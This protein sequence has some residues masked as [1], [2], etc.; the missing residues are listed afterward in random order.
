MKH[1]EKHNA[2]YAFVKGLRIGGVAAALALLL[3]AAA[4]PARGEEDV[5]WHIDPGVETCSM[6]IDPA[7]TQDQWHS[8]VKQVGAIASFK[9]LAPAETLGRMNFRISV[10]QGNTPVDQRDPAWIN[11]FV[12][13][14]KE[15]PLGDAISYPIIRAALG[16][17]DHVDVGAYWTTAPGANYGMVGGEVKYAFLQE[18]GTRPAAA[19]R[20]SATVLTGVDDFDIEIYSLD[21]LASKKI[22]MLKPYAGLRGNYVVGTETTGKVDLDRERLLVPQ[23]FVGL[24]YS[25]WRLDLAVEYNVS[26]VNTLALSVGLRI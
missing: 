23:G 1:V 12:H 13:P 11:T 18:T 10:E 7:L 22:A 2:E 25:F 19:V 14:D 9:A 6:V 3:L 26:T 24:A 17:S 8:F 16:V 5:Y 4:S 20:A 15:C 21:L